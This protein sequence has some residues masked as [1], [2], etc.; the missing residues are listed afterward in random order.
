M[1]Y[2]I[3]YYDELFNV[4]LDII[5]NMTDDAVAREDKVRS[6]EIIDRLS[7]IIIEFGENTHELDDYLEERSY[8]KG[9]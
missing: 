3:E 2:D 5:H 1:S 7:D 6:E 8:G 9:E 4:I